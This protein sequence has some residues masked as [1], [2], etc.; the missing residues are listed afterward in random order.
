MNNHKADLKLP[1]VI[2][3][4]LAGLLACS[5]APKAGAGTPPS[6]A[7]VP[8]AGAVRAGLT[9]VASRQGALLSAVR[10]TPGGDDA[11]ADVSALPTNVPEVQQPTI[12]AVTPMSGE[13]KPLT[14]LPIFT[15]PVVNHPE[16]ITGMEAMIER[17]N[18][19]AL[20]VDPNTP[21]YYVDENTPTELGPVSSTRTNPGTP[22]IN[23]VAKD[24]IDAS[25]TMQP[26]DTDMDVGTGNYIVTA[27]NS[28]I[29]VYDKSGTLLA[30]P[31]SVQGIFSTAGM[32]NC[33]GSNPSVQGFVG[34]DQIRYDEESNRWYLVMMFIHNSGGGRTSAWPSARPTIPPARGGDG[35]S[36]RMVSST[37]FRTIRTWGSDRMRP[38]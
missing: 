32:Y 26:P 4:M 18:A 30:G 33:G 12:I 28:L 16:P 37:T 14:E 27:Y 25:T 6:L 21:T 38:S 1:L 9:P 3:A 29:K 15:G 13:S 20:K 31:T 19:N 5:P 7:L 10:R 34:D 17:L 24:D 23:P 2:T 11:V 22:S 8:P 35:R 36:F